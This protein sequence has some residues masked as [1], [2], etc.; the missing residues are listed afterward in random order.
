MT[1]SERNFLGDLAQGCRELEMKSK[2][3]LRFGRIC[4]KGDGNLEAM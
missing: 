2:C 1:K 4:S 3:C